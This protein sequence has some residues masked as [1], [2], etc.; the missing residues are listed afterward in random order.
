MNGFW[1]I[2]GEEEK[3]GK[4]E[5]NFFH[6]YIYRDMATEKVYELDTE[7]K[8]IFMHE[9]L[10]YLQFINTIFGISY[11]IIYNNYYGF[12]RE[13]F[14][15]HDIIKIP[16]S[17]RPLY[18]E[19]DAYIKQYTALKGSSKISISI[20]KIE[21]NQTDI[22]EAKKN[23]IGVNALGINTKSGETEQFIFG[24]LCIIESMADIFQSFFD[25]SVKHR[26]IPYNAVQII[27]DNYLPDFARDKRMLFSI[28]LCSLM[29]NNPAYG[30]FE[31]LDI[32]RKNPRM[33][34]VALY[35]HVL[36]ESEL[37]HVT[38]KTLKEL[39]LKFISD[40]Q[41]NIESAIGS[42]LEYFSKVFDNCSY[43]VY[44]EESFLLKLL[45][46]TDITSDNSIQLLF[47]FYGLPLVEANDLIL[48]AKQ[49]TGKTAYKDIALLRGLEMVI[50]RVS[51]IIDKSKYPIYN[52]QC[53]LYEQCLKFLYAEGQPQ[54]EMS[55]DCE[56]KQWQKKE[57]CLMTE[58]LKIYRLY[59]KNII[60]L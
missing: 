31:V 44:R 8:G 52:S 51:P 12:C 35:K 3:R 29:Y 28:C 22:L 27:C 4:C 49:P 45:Y 50:N 15:K 53:P 59:G 18:P 37:H 11:G 26:E 47:D 2:I 10:H 36:E 24:Y 1:D 30:F 48:M 14:A 60:Q 39:F 46:E 58:S 7:T 32:V 43:E 20:N 57:I 42:N 23:K 55:R 13:Y 6:I 40:Y 5:T 41:S 19:I 38:C 33:N 9:Y 21:V 54:A 56:N 16:L 17:I 34:G 25:V